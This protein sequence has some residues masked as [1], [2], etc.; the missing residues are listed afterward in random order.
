[1]AFPSGEDI[2]ISLRC[3]ELTLVEEIVEDYSLFRSQKLPELAQFAG[4][5]LLD[6]TP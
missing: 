3:V 4:F 6:Y 2:D 1:M 5:L